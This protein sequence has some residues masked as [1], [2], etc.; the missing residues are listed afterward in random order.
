MERWGRG[1]C[2]G[3]AREVIWELVR[4]G[5]PWELLRNSL[6]VFMNDEGIIGPVGAQG[7]WGKGIG[8]VWRS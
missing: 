7:L 5:A 2:R 1:D 3:A 4:S 6:E 8:Q